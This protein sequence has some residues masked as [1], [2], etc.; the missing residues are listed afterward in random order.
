[1]SK[2]YVVKEYLTSEDIKKV[3]ETL[4]MTQKEFAEFVNCSKRTVEN[5]ES[6]G[7]NIK[8]PIVPL[9]EI[10]M[11]QPGF[12]KKLEIPN[13]KLKLRLWYMYENMTCTI[14]DVD[15]VSREVKIRNYVDNTL[16]RAFGVNTEPSFEEYEDFLE[17]RCFPRSRDKMKI[18]LKKLGIPFYDPI[19][20]IEKT[21]G[22]M[23]DDKFWIKIER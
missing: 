17:S 16:Y 15:E 1:M 20:I 2:K 21:E 3:R 10:L 5:W 23:A 8:G 4:A 22:R 19:M 14:I 13:K 6:N 18:E 7:E 9:V 11:R 12:V